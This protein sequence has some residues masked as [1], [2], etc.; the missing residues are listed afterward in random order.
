MAN[1]LAVAI[2]AAVLLIAAPARA[3]DCVNTTDALN[4]T[5]SAHPGSQV[6]AFYEDLDAQMYIRMLNASP[7]GPPFVV[8]N[9]VIIMEKVGYNSVLVLVFHEYADRVCAS[10]GQSLG[11]A[12]TVEAHAQWNSIITGS[13]L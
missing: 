7:W 2:T 8:G 4:R 1:F 3:T 6:I 10:V 11:V 12:I 5:M 13:E 9:T